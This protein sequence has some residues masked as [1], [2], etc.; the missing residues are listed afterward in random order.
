[1]G[2]GDVMT[3]GSTSP[4]GT[5]LWD[6]YSSWML[7]I[8]GWDRFWLTVV[9]LMIIFSLAMFELSDRMRGK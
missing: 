9:G 5:Q 7:S 1:M 3:H 6:S 8:S 2:L 4:V